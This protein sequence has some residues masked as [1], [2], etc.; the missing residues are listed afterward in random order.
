MYLK[1]SSDGPFLPLLSKQIF[2]VTQ[3]FTIDTVIAADI[4]LFGVYDLPGIQI[5]S[6]TMSCLLRRKLAHNVT[7][8]EPL[9]DLLAV[10]L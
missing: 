9:D 1:Q 10:T 4:V 8:T 2:T 7:L 5:F 3:L 6:T